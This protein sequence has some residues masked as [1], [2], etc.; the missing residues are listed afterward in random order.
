MGNRTTV[1]KYFGL[2]N[3]IGSISVSSF[4]AKIL[5]MSPAIAMCFPQLGSVIFILSTIMDGAS[6]L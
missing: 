1:R 6:E 2:Y 5:L 3:T 4:D